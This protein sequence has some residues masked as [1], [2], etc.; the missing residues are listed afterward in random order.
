MTTRHF[1]SP[2]AVEPCNDIYVRIVVLATHSDIR[3]FKELS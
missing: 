1:P 3:N 2:L